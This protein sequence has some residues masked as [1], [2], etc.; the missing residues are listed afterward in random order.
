LVVS[1]TQGDTS[2]LEQHFPQVV[3]RIYQA[4][5]EAAKDEFSFEVTDRLDELAAT[6]RQ[7]EAGTV[8][9][10]PAVTDPQEQGTA[11]MLVSGNLKS[12]AGSGSPL[13]VPEVNDDLGDLLEVKDISSESG[14]GAAQNLINSALRSQQITSNR[15]TKPSKAAKR[16]RQPLEDLLEIKTVGSA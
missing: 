11:P 8:L 3:E 6:V 14:G 4:G 7:L 10:L 1:L 16:H 12:L 15:P 5:V 2:V 9:A 13:P